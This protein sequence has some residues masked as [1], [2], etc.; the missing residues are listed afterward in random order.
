MCRDVAGRVAVRKAMRREQMDG[1]EATKR[2]YW[3]T[4]VKIEEYRDAIVDAVDT[5][6]LEQVINDVSDER[7]E[8][9]VVTESLIDRL[10]EAIDF[11]DLFASSMIEELKDVVMSA[12]KEGGS[13]LLTVDGEKLDPF[14]VSPERIV[15]Q[16]QT[17]DVYL[18]RLSSDAEERV[19]QSLEQGVE[20]GKSLSEMK[21]DLVGDV[22]ELTEHRAETIARSEVTK[23]SSKGTQQAMDEAGVER[24]KVLAAI[25][26]RTCEQ[27]AFEWRS[28][29]GRTFTSCREWHDEEFRREDAPTPVRDSH[30]NCRCALVVVT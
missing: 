18:K 15:D 26:D 20:Q 27:G 5:D 4:G 7:R 17:Q 21:D 24:V 2:A 28:S 6:P 12:Y 22:E 10:I 16:L 25:D 8:E 30:P 11:E 3:G 14:D 23:A 13:R 19:R 9:R 1:D 29:D